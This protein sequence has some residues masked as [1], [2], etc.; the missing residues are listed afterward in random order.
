MN[1]LIRV[2]FITF[3]D[4][5]RPINRP[6]RYPYYCTGKGFV[7]AVLVSYADGLDYIMANWPDAHVLG[8][9]EVDSIE[10]DERFPKRFWYKEATE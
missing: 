8:V 6:V 7:H 9:E 5:Y 1:G 2:R 4:D 3:I 10:F